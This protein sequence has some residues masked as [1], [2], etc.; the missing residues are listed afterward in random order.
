[1][2]EA[3]EAL[4]AAVTRAA[5]VLHSRVGGVFV[6]GRKIDGPKKERWLSNEAREL[7]KRMKVAERG[8]PGNRNIVLELRKM[9]R[10]QV[11]IDKRAFVNQ[12]RQKIKQNMI[13]DVKKFWAKF[14]KGRSV[15]AV[16]SVNQWSDYFSKLFNEG[17]REW[18][19]H[20]SFETHCRTYEDLFGRPVERDTQGAACLNDVVQ[21]LE[22]DRALTAM[23]L[24]KAVGYDRIPA[25]FFRQA[26]YEVRYVGDDGKPRIVREYLLTPFLTSLFQKI[27]SNK[28]YPPEWAIGVI[29]PVPKP[30]GDILVMDNYRGIAVG[31]AISK[32]FAQVLMA[33]IDRWAESYGWRAPT[34]FGFRKD[35]GTVDAVFML[36]HLVD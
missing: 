12:S 4:S 36:R 16:H 27:L 19:D 14:K 28:H 10:R 32:I 31:S 20:E 5:E 13:V 34:Q 29:T 33:R 8:L 30:K 26:Y 3:C 17:E 9:Y 18:S 25:E 21:E 6:S 35:K 24:G 1:M 7:R 11:R 2:Q 23:N 15:G 22:V